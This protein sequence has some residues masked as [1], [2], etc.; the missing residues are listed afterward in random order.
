M[1]E[2]ISFISILIYLAVFFW[3]VLY[4]VLFDFR[5]EGSDERGVK[6]SG[7]AY[8]VAFPL[9]ILGWLFLE[10]IDTYIRPLSFEEYR[11]AIWFLVTVP[12]IVRAGMILLLK[13]FW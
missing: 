9:V 1:G 6:I 11:D 10:L 5:K 12:V 3:G 2:I 13:R 8:T 4:G 7:T